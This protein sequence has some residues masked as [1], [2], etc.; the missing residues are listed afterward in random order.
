M[1]YDLLIAD[2]SGVQIVTLPF[3]WLARMFAWMRGGDAS[4][5]S[6]TRGRSDI[7]WRR[8]RKAGRQYE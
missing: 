2:R 4:Y 5:A 7:I 6:I 3:Y 8:E 1:G